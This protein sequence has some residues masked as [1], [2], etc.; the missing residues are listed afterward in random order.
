MTNARKKKTKAGDSI[1]QDVAPI[2]RRSSNKV[3][4]EEPCGTLIWS[5]SQL[6]IECGALDKFLVGR[7]GGALEDRLIIL[8]KPDLQLGRRQ[9]Q[10]RSSQCC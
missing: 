2:N 8:Q 6:S 4:P 7:R 9:W 1:V 5:A 3:H 10:L